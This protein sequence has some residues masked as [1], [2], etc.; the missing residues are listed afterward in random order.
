MTTPRVDDPALA[1]LAWPFFGGEHRALA[2]AL[3]AWAATEIA[4]LVVHEPA[5]VDATFRALVRT[6]GTGGWL[7]YS[8][9][10][11]FG[12]APP[13]LDVRT[14]CLARETL[15]QLSG[16]A[17]FAF[18]MQGL[19]AGPI[20]LFGTDP[21]KQRYLPRVAAGDAIAAFAISEPLAGSDVSAMET[22]AH[23]DGSGYVIEG[24]KTWISNAGIA[25]FYV[26]FAR[27]DGDAD[28][29][30]IALVVDADNPGL[31]VSE[32]IAVNAPHPLGTLDFSRCRVPES[33]VVGEPG[34]GM[35]VALGTLDVFR[36]TVGAA[37]LGF[38]RR[39]LEEATTHALT[40]RVFG[41]RLADMQMTQAKL[42]DMAMRVD[43][44]ALLV[45]R[46][47]WTRDSGAPRITREAAMAKL[48][49]TESAQ[50]VI[51][52]AVQLFGGRGVVVGEPVERLYREIRALRIYE[53]TSEI[54]QLV[55]AGQLIAA[56]EAQ[57]RN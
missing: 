8:V 26:V 9:P 30:F 17:D 16:M 44:S 20:S 13:R 19:G 42:A 50:R 6:L 27:L 29:S 41:Q 15:G 4:P 48:H 39:A 24:R 21:L 46:A 54:Q 55:I 23:R 35:R 11:P 38:A 31:D 12:L 56:A 28:R 10:A 53:G 25:D 18:G 5:D 1:H 52:D 37:A 33:A 36:S 34:K 32:R 43:A 49:A 22:V 3:R 2:T 7:R 47:A 45:Y 14:L 40:R 57:L 51:D